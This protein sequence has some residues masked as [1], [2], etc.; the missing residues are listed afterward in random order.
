MKKE[1]KV[2]GMRCDHCRMNVQKA[3]EAVAGVTSVVVDREACKATVE[4]DFDPE[5]VIEAVED[6]GFNA[7]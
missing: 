6:L 3:I 7:E 1:F 2:T 5:A 4:G